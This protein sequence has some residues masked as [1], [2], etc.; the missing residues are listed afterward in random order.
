MVDPY[1][2]SQS[3]SAGSLAQRWMDTNIK[4]DV[5]KPG[6]TKDQPTLLYTM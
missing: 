1:S 5:V 6:L 3:C 4:H 2:M